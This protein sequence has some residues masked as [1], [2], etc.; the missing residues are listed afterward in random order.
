MLIETP[1]IVGSGSVNVDSVDEVL[2]RVAIEP[3][4]KL[5][6]TVE[7]RGDF[8]NELQTRSFSIQLDNSA[9]SLVTGLGL[10]QLQGKIFAHYSNSLCAGA[11]GFLRKG[12]CGS[13]E[14]EKRSAQR[15]KRKRCAMPQLLP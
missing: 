12:T 9:R 14:C 4:R 8:L 1:S 13:P 15:A 10:A 3:G 11:V 5:P 7:S 6:R 2:A